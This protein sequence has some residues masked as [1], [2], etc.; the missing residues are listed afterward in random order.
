MSDALE[1]DV[2]S[3]R[4]NGEIVAVVPEY[5]SGPGWT[6]T[7]V[8]VIWVDSEH[9]LHRDCLQPHE[10]SAELL[11]LFKIGAVV[12]ERLIAAVERMNRGKYE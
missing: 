3:K 11:T 9:K 8:W 7:P 1:S 4:F 5:C 2:R 6:N 12:N 10:Q